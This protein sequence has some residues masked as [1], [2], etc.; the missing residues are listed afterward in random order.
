LVGFIEV[1]G[2]VLFLFGEVKTSSETTNR[3]PQV[4]TT[5][6]KNIESQLRGLY[7]DIGKRRILISYLQNK[8]RHYPSGHPFFEDFEAGKRAYY[9]G[10]CRF[11][12][13]G[14][15]IRDIS[16]DERD[17][18]VSYNRLREQILEPKGLKLLALYLPI[19]KEDWMTIINGK[20][21]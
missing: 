4:M 10:E 20:Q 15:L 7:D 14:V 17:V 11:H 8:A 13:F 3:P 9:S 18:S 16:P 6:D 12:L 1:N 5:S 19:Q 2:Q 21:E